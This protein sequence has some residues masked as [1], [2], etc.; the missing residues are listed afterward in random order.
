MI[1]LILGI[2]NVTL[3]FVAFAAN[4]DTGVE[5]ILLGLNIGIGTLMTLF[6]LEKMGVIRR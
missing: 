3:G 5:I 4:P 2:I 6:G 1:L